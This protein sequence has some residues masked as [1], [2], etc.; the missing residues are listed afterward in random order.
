MKPKEKE[1]L[2]NALDVL[3]SVLTD[4]MLAEYT[5]LEACIKGIR[6]GEFSDLEF[7]TTEHTIE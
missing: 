3:S 6:T 7:L 5:L 4:N 1:M 2:I